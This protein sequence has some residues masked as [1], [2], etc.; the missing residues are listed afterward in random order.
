MEMKQ[1]IDNFINKYCKDGCTIDSEPVEELLNKIYKTLL[2]T[3]K[4]LKKRFCLS[5]EDGCNCSKCKTID[6]II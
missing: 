4:E 2:N 5:E 6:K 3:N 1:E